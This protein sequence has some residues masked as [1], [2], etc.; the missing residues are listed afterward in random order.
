MLLQS[1]LTMM[2]VIAIAAGTNALC[3]GLDEQD[4]SLT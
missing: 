2:V 1:A 4:S 3:H